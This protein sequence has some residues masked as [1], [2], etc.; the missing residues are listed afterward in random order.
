MR[1]WTL[2]AGLLLMFLPAVIWR[3][4][5]NEIAMPVDVLIDDLDERQVT[6]L[7]WSEDGYRV[8]LRDGSAYQV[9]DFTGFGD[10]PDLNATLM[11]SITESGVP[12]EEE[13]SNP[14]LVLMFALGVLLVLVGALTWLRQRQIQ[15]SGGGIN[16]N[17]LRDSPAR[18]VPEASVKE[19]FSDVGGAEEAK[20]RL[21]DVLDFLSEPDRWEAAGIRMPRGVLF[22]GPPGCGKTLLA[23]AVAGEAGV[24]F[25]SVSASELVEVFVGV[26]AARVRNLFD[27]ATKVAPSVVFIDEIDAVGRR[28]GANTIAGFA[29]WEQTL[30][31]LLVCMDGFE[32]GGR[33]VVV[34]A[35]NRADILDPAL[36]RPGRFDSRVRMGVFTTE[37]R[38]AILGIHT[39]GK[40][41]GEVD[42]G[43]VAEDSAGMTGAQ[44]ELLCNTAAIFALRRGGPITNADFREAQAMLQKYDTTVSPLDEVLIDSDVRRV[45]PD[46]ELWVA[47][48]RVGSSELRGRLLWA[49]RRLLKIETVDGRKVIL[50]KEMLLGL[51][52]VAPGSVAPV[53]DEEASA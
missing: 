38:A 49:D 6:H 19:R 23:R 47:A 4:Q 5:G 1:T 22:E 51:E 2:W 9:V 13:E 20:A 42:L 35:T 17:T 14:I 26:G 10:T 29:E 24:P 12:F 50:P 44:L 30:N 32:K 28:R 21:R 25:F 39:R 3:S 15:N 11:R 37:D 8:E 33:V 27:E 45:E 53:E 52:A 34:A 16:L 7:W 48:T 41:V 43:V 40:A 31:Q 18:L 36:L 46:Q